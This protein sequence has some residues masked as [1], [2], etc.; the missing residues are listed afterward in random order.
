[1]NKKPKIL[2]L[3]LARGGSKGLPKKNIKEFCGKP[4]I[5]WTISQAI[6]SNEFAKVVVSTD[7]IEIS[8]VSNK[9]GAETPF[10]RPAALS[11]DTSPS[12][13]AV[14]HCIEYF[15]QHEEDFD[16]VCLLEPTSPLRTANQLQEIIRSFN[17]RSSEFNSLITVGRVREPLELFKS[18]DGKKLISYENVSNQHI[19]LRRQDAKT[20]YFPYGVAYIAKTQTLVEEKTFYSQ[21]S[22]YFVI[23]DDQCFEIDDQIDFDINEHLFQ[24]YYYNN[25]F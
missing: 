19:S 9:A 1:M 17:D 23:Q 13:D 22:T 14:L 11:A 7:C 25:Q 12:I 8:E 10:L 16:A 20:Q 4:L 15:S 18:L 6:G 5:A 24:K 2:G 3:I 21:K